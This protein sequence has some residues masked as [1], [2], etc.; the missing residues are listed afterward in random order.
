MAVTATVQYLPECAAMVGID[1]LPITFEFAPFSWMHSML[2]PLKDLSVM[3]SWDVLL[4][5]L[6]ALMAPLLHSAVPRS[7]TSN[8]LR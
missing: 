6:R 8:L 3:M 7:K 2:L 1:E 5:F 4:L